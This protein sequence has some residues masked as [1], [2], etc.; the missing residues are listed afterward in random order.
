[1]A[2]GAFPLA[3]LGFLVVK[4]ISKPIANAIARRAKAS[5]VFRTYVCIPTAQLFHWYD[6]KVRMRMLNLG[7]ATIVPKLNQ[8]K[9]IE[10]GS[11][12]L[13]EMIILSI[14]SGLLIFEYNRSAEKEDAKQE[15][16]EREKAYLMDKVET[17]ELDVNKQAAEIRQLTR[18][19]HHL[20]DQL[21]KKSLRA[22]LGLAGPNPIQPEPVS[23][24][25]PAAETQGP[26]DSTPLV[27][28]AAESVVGPWAV[29]DPSP[30]PRV[31]PG[32][33][34]AQCVDPPLH[35]NTI[36]SGTPPIDRRVVHIQSATMATTPASENWSTYV[37]DAFFQELMGAGRHRLEREAQSLSA[38]SHQLEEETRAMAFDHYPTFIS[39]ADCCH[40]IAGQFARNQEQV[41]ALTRDLPQ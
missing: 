23:H 25:T 11:Q 18:H 33:H 4:Q 19:I 41:S 34:F 8:D 13:S 6:V 1:M 20:S 36:K 37:D 21:Y 5:R 15:Q 28:E 17:M 39:A 14:A 2:V 22:Q 40:D 31:T 10:T 35:V 24:A 32:L 26:E 29:S 9:A 12:L 3:K 7:K 38:R 27:I 16:T 30:F